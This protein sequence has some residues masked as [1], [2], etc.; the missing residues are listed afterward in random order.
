MNIF[1][2]FKPKDSWFLTSLETADILR[3]SV[4]TIY[5]QASLSSSMPY[6][7]FGTCIRWSKIDVINFAPRTAIPMLRQPLISANCVTIR[8]AGVLLNISKSSAY[9]LC[10]NSAE[11]NAPIKTVTAETAVTVQAPSISVRFR[12]QRVITVDALRRY[13]LSCKYQDPVNLTPRIEGW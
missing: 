13:I 3:C 5:R 6:Y 11:S 2:G 10:S 4:S 8:Q 12:L 9:R 7:I 1:S